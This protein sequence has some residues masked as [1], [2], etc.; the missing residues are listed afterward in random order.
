MVAGAIHGLGVSMGSDLPD[1]IEDPRFNYDHHTKNGVIYG[2]FLTQVKRS[3][4]KR[5]DAEHTWGWKYPRAQVYMRDV[6]E[7][8]INPCLVMV[9][10]DPIPATLRVTARQGKAHFDSDRV[11]KTMQ[12][13]MRM[14]QANMTLIN[15]LK[16]P[17]LTVSYERAL[18]MPEV[19]LAELAAFVGRDLPCD[20]SDLLNFMTPGSYKK[21]PLQTA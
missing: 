18:K 14:V 6:V 17:T 5:N 19:F 8:L 7:D 20:V 4:A 12:G 15:E 11:L 13:Q 16:V 3:I 1:N 21:P 10:R 9:F 2:D